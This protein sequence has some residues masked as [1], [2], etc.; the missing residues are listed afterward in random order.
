MIWPD[1]HNDGAGTAQGSVWPPL[2]WHSDKA[3]S[4]NKGLEKGGRQYD[5]L[6]QPTLEQQ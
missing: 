2:R 5:L 6:M 4:N 1:H 3:R